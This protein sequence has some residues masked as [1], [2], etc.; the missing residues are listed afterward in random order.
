ML[1]ALGVRGAL[2]VVNGPSEPHRVTL[3]VAEWT[4]GAI[5]YLS[6]SSTAKLLT[7]VAEEEADRRLFIKGG[8]S[9]VGPDLYVLDGKAQNQLGTRTG[10]WEGAPGAQS[11]LA[12]LAGDSVLGS[13]RLP[14]NLSPRDVTFVWFQPEKIFVF[15]GT[16]SWFGHVP[17]TER[18]RAR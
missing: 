16:K 10:R 1:L 6:G 8:V 17:R 14:G 13:I 3:F 11:E 15:N 12:L 4:L 2:T 18:D 7:G 9:P 5:A